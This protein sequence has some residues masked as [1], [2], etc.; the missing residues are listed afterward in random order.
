MN[1]RPGAPFAGAGA[2]VVVVVVFVT[3]VDDPDVTRPDGADATVVLPLD[4]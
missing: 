4:E 3:V 2:V 1:V